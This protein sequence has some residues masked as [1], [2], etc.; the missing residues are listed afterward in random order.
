MWLALPPAYL[1]VA[2]LLHALAVRMRPS[3]NRV[4]LFLVLG[5]LTGVALI[6]HVAA[7]TS[8]TLPAQAAVVLLYAFGCELYVFLFTFVTSSVSVALLVSP[9]PGQPAGAPA[10]MV[11][12]RLAVMHAAGLLQVA[13]AGY[14]LTPRARHLVRIYRDLRG[15][16]RHRT[17]P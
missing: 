6:W 7:N 3:G 16:F 4:H 5:S 12:R 8:L 2:L 13:A 1:V 11:R 9:G 15:F 10:E 14:V 17:N